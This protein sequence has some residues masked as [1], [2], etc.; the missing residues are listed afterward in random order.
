MTLARI[1]LRTV[2]AILE[3]TVDRIATIVARTIIG[4]GRGASHAATGHSCCGWNRLVEGLVI[5]ALH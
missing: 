3:S 2:N 5:H 1:A 4:I